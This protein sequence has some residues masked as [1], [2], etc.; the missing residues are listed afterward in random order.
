MLCDVGSLGGL[1]YSV[2]GI[3]LDLTTF[4]IG[5]LPCIE[6]ERLGFHFPEPSRVWLPIRI[7]AC[8]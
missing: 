3:R 7:R 5:G 2:G 1:E 4:S 8:Q 6:E